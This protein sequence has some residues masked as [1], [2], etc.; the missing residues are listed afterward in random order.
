MGNADDITRKGKHL[1]TMEKYYI[2]LETFR[3]TQIN[4]NIHYSEKQ[5]F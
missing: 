4:D 3:G 1:D 2:Y 5:D